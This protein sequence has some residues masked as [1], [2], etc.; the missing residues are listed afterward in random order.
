MLPLTF[1]FLTT[2]ISKAFK[3]YTIHFPNPLYQIYSPS[4]IKKKWKEKK[5]QCWWCVPRSMMQQWF[6]TSTQERR[7]CTYPTVLPF[8]VASLSLTDVSLLHLDQTRINPSLAAL[9]TSG[10]PIRCAPNISYV[11]Y[12]REAYDSALS[13]LLH[14]IMFLSLSLLYGVIDLL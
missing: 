3:L 13:L 1:L 14:H 4:R 11:L 8:H 7:F 5:R 10:L 6:M 9:S 12:E 2:L